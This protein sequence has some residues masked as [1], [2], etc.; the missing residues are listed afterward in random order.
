MN[1]E[2]VFFL[3]NLEVVNVSLLENFVIM[4]LLTK[5]NSITKDKFK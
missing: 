2:V 4:M 3:M 1:L 5:I